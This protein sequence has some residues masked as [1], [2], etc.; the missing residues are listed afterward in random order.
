MVDIRCRNSQYFRRRRPTGRIYVL[1]SKPLQLCRERDNKVC[2][3]VRNG[4]AVT[5]FSWAVVRSRNRLD[6]SRN[7]RDVPLD[8]PG[9]GRSWW[10]LVGADCVTVSLLAAACSCRSALARSSRRGESSGNAAGGSSAGASASSGQ[11]L[12]RSAVQSRTAGA[13]AGSTAVVVVV[14]GGG[15]RGRGPRD[16]ASSPRCARRSSSLPR[17]SPARKYSIPTP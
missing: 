3:A 8:S 13:F 12:N 5:L 10:C 14:P 1:N 16:S 7:C 4:M 2:D 9:P 15:A 17:P 6:V 11:L